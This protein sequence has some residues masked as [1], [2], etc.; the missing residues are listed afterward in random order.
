MVF[1]GVVRRKE[2]RSAIRFRQSH[3]VRLL[4]GG[5]GGFESEANPWWTAQKGEVSIGFQPR[6]FGHYPGSFSGTLHHCR[7]L[8]RRTGSEHETVKTA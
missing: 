4:S 8:E 2:N 6:S 1:N 7:P 5:P 3:A